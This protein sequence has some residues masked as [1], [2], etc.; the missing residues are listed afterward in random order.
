MGSKMG[1]DTSFYEDPTSCICVILPTKTNR[2][3]HENNTFL[4]EA[5]ICISNL[6]C[7][8]AYNL[9]TYIIHARF[10]YLCSAIST[11]IPEIV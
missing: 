7:T 4:A 2:Q 9:S 3:S 11:V 8:T 1:K 10:T 5:I 6:F